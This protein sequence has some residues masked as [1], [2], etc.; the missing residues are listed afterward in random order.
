[1]GNKVPFL[2]RRSDGATSL[3]RSQWP[4]L[5]LIGD[6]SK[7]IMNMKFHLLTNGPYTY[8]ALFHNKTSDGRGVLG[9]GLKVSAPEMGTFI[10][11]TRI[12]GYGSECILTGEGAVRYPSLVDLQNGG[13]SGF[14]SQKNDFYIKI[15]T[16]RLFSVIK[17]SEHGSSRDAISGRFGI[18]CAGPVK[19]FVEGRVDGFTVDGTGTYING[20]ACDYGSDSQIE[21]QVS[22]GAASG[23]RK[24][25][26]RTI[27]SESAEM[28]VNF[29]C[30]D[31]SG[32]GHR[33][34]VKIPP[35][36]LPQLR[37]QRVF[38]EGISRKNPTAPLRHSGSHVFP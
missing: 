36:M 5:D 17:P 31:S 27:A 11:V 37:G 35:E 32:V 20:W 1:M 18:K 16:D 8:D 15:K 13:T 38:V 7:P 34:R 10:P 3:A 19:S 29:A 28:A 6:L 23:P 22:G 2:M 33:Y 14:F 24:L 4:L 30:A 9:L 25:I 12:L 26:S 21:I